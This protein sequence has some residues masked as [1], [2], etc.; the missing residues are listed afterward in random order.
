M[1]REIK[2]R[3]WD[4][5]LERWLDHEEFGFQYMTTSGYPWTEMKVVF[6]TR[7]KDV[8]VMQYTGLKDKNGK[9][10]YEGDI[11]NF[12]DNDF[13]SSPGTYEV[14]WIK[15]SAGFG[16]RGIHTYMHARGLDEP[17]VLDPEEEATNHVV[18]DV[19]PNSE[20]I[21]NIYENK[22]LL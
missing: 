8:E 7:L 4:K 20:V 5:K 3:A 10:I 22:E 1:T 18:S 19:F 2:F 11:V 21:G 9:E 12:E 16:M 17:V 14:A 6:D 15:D 13:I